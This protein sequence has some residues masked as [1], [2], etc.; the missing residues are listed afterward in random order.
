MDLSKCVAA[1]CE[2]VEFAKPKISE[3]SIEK[4]STV[5]VDKSGD[6]LCRKRIIHQKFDQIIGL[7]KN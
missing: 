6:V 5:N 2:S 4:A 7:H 3:I 1:G